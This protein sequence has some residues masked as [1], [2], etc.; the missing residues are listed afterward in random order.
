MTDAP[1]FVG[2][3][4]SMRVCMYCGRL[5]RSQPVALP[6]TIYPTLPVSSTSGNC[7]VRPRGMLDYAKSR[8]GGEFHD[9]VVEDVR[10]L[11][12]ILIVFLAIIPYWTVYFQVSELFTG[13]AIKRL[14]IS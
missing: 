4:H 5:C 14:T 13:E 3:I 12:K 2:A 10:V 1:T 7:A 11:G 9:H 8:F 6:P